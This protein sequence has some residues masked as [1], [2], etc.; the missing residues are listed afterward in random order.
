[1]KCRNKNCNNEMYH[2]PKG[3]MCP[4]WEMAHA[5]NKKLCMCCA[6]KEVKKL[7][8]INNTQFNN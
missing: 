4:T 3:G 7:R 5:L 2:P 6:R 8:Q 1:M